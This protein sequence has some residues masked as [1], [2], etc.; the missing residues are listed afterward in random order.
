MSSCRGGHVTLDIST[1]TS[2]RKR[3]VRPPREGAGPAT[4]LVVFGGA[5]GLDGA[6]AGVF[7]VVVLAI[8]L[9]MPFVGRLAGQEG[10]EPPTSGFGDRRSTVGATALRSSSDRISDSPHAGRPCPYF[11]SLCAVCEP[12]HLQNFWNS[13]RSGS[14]RLFFIVV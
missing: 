10:F 14:F 6:F 1:R 11:V 13:S 8:V 2:R 9:R 3:M 4:G 7:V 5:A 12:H